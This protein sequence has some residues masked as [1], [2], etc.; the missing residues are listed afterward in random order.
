MQVP[1]AYAEE[2]IGVRGENIEFIRSVS[3]A[4]VVLE[5]IGDYQKV[6]VMIEGTPSQVQTAHQ[7]VQVISNP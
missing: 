5:E 3:G 7:L 1:L 2:I 6:R 4:V